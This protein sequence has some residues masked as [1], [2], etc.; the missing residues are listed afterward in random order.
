MKQGGCRRF[1]VS[2]GGYGKEAG[3]YGTFDCV[4]ERAAFYAAKLRGEC[5]GVFSGAEVA[6]L[7]LGDGTN[8]RE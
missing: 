7:A 1:L 5:F 8:G 3:M 4:D 6:P 2:E